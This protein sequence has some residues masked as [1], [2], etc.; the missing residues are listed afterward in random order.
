MG[1]PGLEPRLPCFKSDPGI[2]DIMVPFVSMVFQKRGAW[3]ILASLAPHCG[4]TTVSHIRIIHALFPLK[5][6]IIMSKTHYWGS[7][8]C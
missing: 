7:N 1:A 3:K 8:N 6:R 5:I 4:G 2:T